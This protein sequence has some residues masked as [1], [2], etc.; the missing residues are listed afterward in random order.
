MTAE[1]D[2]EDSSRPTVLLTGHA[3]AL[4]PC[5]GVTAA[6]A[7]RA[8]ARMHRESLAQRTTTTR[9][10]VGRETAASPGPCE[11]RCS[12]KSVSRWS[13][14][15]SRGTRSAAAARSSACPPSRGCPEQAAQDTHR[16]PLAEHGNN[17]RGCHP[18]S[19]Q[20]RKQASAGP[21]RDAW[22]GTRG[23]VAPGCC[24][25]AERS[26]APGQ[27]FW[28]GRGSALGPRCRSRTTASS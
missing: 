28:R 6:F 19:M 26:S 3:G 10:V 13:S 21:T 12:S 1:S 16:A 2:E 24:F 25:S 22:F 27:A 11:S 7:G 9:V 17:V 20:T 15:A 18:A 4:I 23:P 14:A 8:S 5:A